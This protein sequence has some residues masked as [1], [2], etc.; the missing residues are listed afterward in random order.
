MTTVKELACFLI[1]KQEHYPLSDAF[2]ERYQQSGGGYIDFA[3]D[4]G[5]LVE[6]QKHEPNQK[7]HFF[8]SWLMPRLIEYT[9]TDKTKAKLLELSADAEEAVWSNHGLKCPEL[10]LWFLEAVG[11]DSS[12]VEAAKKIA[13]DGKDGNVLPVTIARD[14]KDLI[15]WEVI[16]A[17]IKS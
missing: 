11:V 2:I 1:G 16:E 14:I 9:Y 6:P 10:L 15:P 5:H 7:W 8:E 3:H 17:A 12:K 4:T 13:E